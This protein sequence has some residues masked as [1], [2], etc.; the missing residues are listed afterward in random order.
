MTK[1]K[2]IKALSELGIDH[3]PS[4]LK[5]E[6]AELLSQ[7]KRQ[8]DKVVQA[9]EEAEAEAEPEAAR[10]RISYAEKAP[11]KAVGTPLGVLHRG[12]VVETDEAGL[13]KMHRAF[14][15]GA[16]DPMLR[17]YLMTETLA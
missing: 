16:L 13:E 8:A 17:H 5:A 12:E 6:L 4:S 3:D 7:H 1:A 15:L 2:I 9:T 14:K 11:F 10:Y